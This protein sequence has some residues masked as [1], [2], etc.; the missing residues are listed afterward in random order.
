[1]KLRLSTKLCVIN[2]INSSDAGYHH[3][4]STLETKQYKIFSVYKI[5]NHRQHYIYFY[6]NIIVTMAMARMRMTIQ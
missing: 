2:I 4:S 6:A 3:R 1:M 5:K